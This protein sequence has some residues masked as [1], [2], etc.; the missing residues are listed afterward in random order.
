MPNH[1][2]HSAYYPA[3]GTGY[4]VCECGQVRRVEKGEPMTSWHAPVNGWRYPGLE[5]MPEPDFASAVT[6]GK[7]GRISEAGGVDRVGKV[8]D[9]G[10]VDEPLADASLGFEDE[11][12]EAG[13][14]QEEGEVP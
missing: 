7:A 14:A 2:H 1:E 5:P 3:S 8:D 4:E 9:V 12:V 13:T 10:E 11:G 6:I